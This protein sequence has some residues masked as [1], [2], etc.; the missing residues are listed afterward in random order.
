VCGGK[1]NFN[2]EGEKKVMKK[3]N[4][5]RE[6]RLNACSEKVREF[7]YHV[8]MGHQSK[9]LVDQFN[10]EWRRLASELTLHKSLTL[11][12]YEQGIENLVE[13]WKCLLIH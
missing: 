13:K 3:I 7:F 9:D 10:S 2:Q 12:E 5:S 4:P 8:V 11:S 6:E 1:V